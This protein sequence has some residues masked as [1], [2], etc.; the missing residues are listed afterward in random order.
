[1]KRIL[2]LLPITLLIL[3]CEPTKTE[4]NT[5]LVYVASGTDADGTGIGIYSWN[6]EESELSEIGADSTFGSFSYLTIDK[7]NNLLFGVSKKTIS[8]FE[9]DKRSGELKH[10][11]SQPNVGVNPCHVSVSND[12]KFLVV[13]YYSSGSLATYAIAEG[14]LLA[15]AISIVQHTG[16]SIDSSRQMEPH[17]H[18]VL[19]LPESDLIL[20]PDLGIDKVMTYRLNNSGELTA[21]SDEF[22]AKIR[23]GGGPRHAVIHSEKNYVYVLHELTG[24]VTGFHIDTKQGFKDSINTV[25]TLPADFDG[26]N[27]SADI[28]ITPDGQYLYA[29]NRGHNSI[30]VSRIDETGALTF[31]GTK[32]CG[33]DWPRA[34]AIDPSGQFLLVANQRSNQISIMKID[35]ETGFFEKVGETETVAAPQAIRFIKM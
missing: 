1:M 8:A 4:E 18:Q 11:N 21:V 7:V 24:N 25:S 10:L 27:K 3:S 29:S 12:G 13:G 19:P 20:V 22:N 17:V 26:L 31:L 2:L 6:A 32:S 5:H 14:G 23:P 28:H 33:G 15:E 35:Y 34:F 9:I 16:S 30:A